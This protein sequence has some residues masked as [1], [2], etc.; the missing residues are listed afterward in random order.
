MSS[1]LFHTAYLRGDTR[2][3]T[4]APMRRDV[5]K[6]NIKKIREG[7]NLSQEEFGRPLNASRANVSRYEKGEHITVRLL[8]DIERVY[9][10]GISQILAPSLTQTKEAKYIQK[11]DKDLM[12]EAIKEVHAQLT[13]NKK[14]ADSDKVMDIAIEAYNYSAEHD[15]APK[16]IAAL[17]IKDN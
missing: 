4:I 7:L 17:L 5:I 14:R 11:I 15:V 13:K 6:T 1:G 3:E 2:N 10:I 8:L 16:K 12:A 9:G